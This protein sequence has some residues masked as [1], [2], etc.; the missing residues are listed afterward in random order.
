MRYKLA[1]MF[2]TGSVKQFVKLI[3]HKYIP[4][5]LGNVIK[6]VAHIFISYFWIFLLIIVLFGAIIFLLTEG[7]IELFQNLFIYL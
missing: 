2:I 7:T 5:M 6:F 4:T 3:L 1:T